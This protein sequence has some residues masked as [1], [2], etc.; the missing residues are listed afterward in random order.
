MDDIDNH[1]RAYNSPLPY[2]HAISQQSIDTT[3]NK[4]V[5]EY[6]FLLEKSLQLFAGLRYALL[7]PFNLY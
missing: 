1:A 5:Q 6:Q 2:E 3:T 7:P 4:T